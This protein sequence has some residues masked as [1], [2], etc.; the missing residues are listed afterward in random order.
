M[1]VCWQF[2]RVRCLLFFQ[3][4]ISDI[5]YI[6]A[7]LRAMEV[8]ALSG[9]VVFISSWQRILH[10]QIGYQAQY[11]MFFHPSHALVSSD[12]PT[13]PTLVPQATAVMFWFVLC[14]LLTDSIVILAMCCMLYI[15]RTQCRC[16]QSFHTNQRV[17]ISPFCPNF[18]SRRAHYRV[19]FGLI[20]LRWS[21][22]RLIDIKPPRDAAL[23]PLRLQLRPF[24]WKRSRF[25]CWFSPTSP[26]MSCLRVGG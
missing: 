13:V 10:N 5:S 21:S 12:N 18:E 22:E 2:V 4:L 11:A 19:W 25:D 26:L 23:R 16:L 24:L 17:C 7:Y 14:Q 15:R 9:N 3:F 1:F 20:I 8:K 6:V